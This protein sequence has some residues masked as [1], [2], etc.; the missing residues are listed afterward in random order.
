MVLYTTKLTLLDRTNPNR[1][2]G[3][4]TDL[5]VSLTGTTIGDMNP[6]RVRLELDN[7][8][9]DGEINSGRLTLRVDELKTFISTGPILVDEDAKKKYLIEGQI[10]QSDPAGGADL[11]GKIFRFQLGTPTID[12][13]ENKAGILTITLQEIQYRIKESINA[14]ELRFVTPA[15]ALSL[16]LID[17]NN[18]QAGSGVSLIFSGIGN[19]LPVAPELSY[20]PQSPQTIQ[21]LFD[22]IFKRLEEPQI[23]GGVFTDFYY[24]FDP[25]TT[26]MLTVELKGDEIG[27]I[28]S[29]L[30]LEPLSTTVIDAAGEE[31]IFTD[32]L[33]FK[34]NVVVRGNPQGGSL[35]TEHTKFSSNWEHM[36]IAR[37]W[38]TANSITLRDDITSFNYLAGQ[39]VKRTFDTTAITTDDGSTIPKVIRFFEALTNVG[40]GGGPN[41]PP[42]QDDTNW[43]EHFLIYP[44]YDIH[45]RYFEGDIVYHDSILGTVTFYVAKH[46]ILGFTLGRFREGTQ[47]ALPDIPA[48]ADW[49][50]LAPTVPTR[51]DN[52][53]IGWIPYSPWTANIFDWEKNMG[54]L[55]SGS[56]PTGGATNRYVGFVPDWNMARDIYDK[57]DVTDQF[58]TI[59]IKWI[60][61]K[62]V[63]NPISLTTA[64]IYHGNRVL[65][66]TAGAG[67]FVGQSD[68]L[69]EFDG[70]TSTWR[71]SKTPIANEIV[72]NLDDGK[73]WR[74]TGS[75]WAIA[76]E[77]E[78]I[79]TA[80][81][82]NPVSPAAPFHLVK[83]IYKTRGFDGTP[84]SAIEFRYAWDDTIIG[85]LP[86]PGDD[87]ARKALLARLNSRGSWLWFWNPFPRLPH[88]NGTV[89]GSDDVDIGDNFG[90]NG[91]LSGAVSG[92]TTLNIFNNQSDRLQNLRNW[93]NGL[94]TEDMGKISGIS[95]RLKAGFFANFVDN[96]NDTLHAEILAETTGM[97]NVPMIFWA[98]DDFDRIWFKRFELRRNNRW[99]NV[100]IEFGD[101]SR[102]NLYF[103]R[104]DELPDFLGI[105]LS[106]LS[107]VLKEK[108]FTGVAFDWRFVRGWGIMFAG[109]YD[110]QGF[111][112]AGVGSWWKKLEDTANQIGETFTNVFISVKNWWEAIS[113]PTGTLD[114]DKKIPNALR[115]FRQSTIAIDDL[116]Y[117][118]EQIANSD[119][120]IVVNARTQIE[121]EPNETDYLNAKAIARAKRER[122]SFFPQFW[123]LRSIGDVR[124]RVGEAFTVKGDRTPN[125]PAQHAAWNVATSYNAGDKVSFSDR[126]Y[127]ARQDN[128]GQQPDTN[129]DELGVYSVL[130]FQLY[131]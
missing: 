120:A 53:F 33:R 85:S 54:G 94:N 13:D 52:N 93:N 25:S 31:T 51:D 58:E 84:S 79:D 10:T 119:D 68:K 61:Q 103:A 34:N 70:T 118:K 121:Y 30:V 17:F 104:W 122:L 22:E 1:V 27:R 43:K 110:A 67:D 130:L 97:P 129:P 92:F 115:W 62:D 20:I 123:T 40:V 6:W 21:Q 125:Q 23:T 55:K 71:F 108:E 60:Q 28:D 57:Q 16:R 19:K 112:N 45:G 46:P 35:P 77:V 88:D 113:Q 32:L 4:S 48:G 56:L 8:G 42:D 107:F 66:G 36:R 89:G 102:R 72:I 95:F 99:D 128:I 109:S 65:V 105:P 86:L 117:V 114:P 83:D 47:A 131:M 50:S 9:A 124:M 41:Q 126:V 26:A 101:L 15:E 100:T 44:S 39:T 90:G 11:Q 75:V 59:S 116:H 14:R 82:G 76:W 24:D 12:V 98:I 81:K 38:D 111:Y 69:A 91:S 64:E 63:N 78:R 127:Q 37:E 49:T 3:E 7:T 2:G 106:G 87:A 96:T 80:D 18:H 74:W 73:V 5:P 29:G